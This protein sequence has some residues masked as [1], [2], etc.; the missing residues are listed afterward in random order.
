MIAD[1]V[2]MRFWLPSKGHMQKMSCPKLE[3]FQPVLGLQ[4]ED[5]K[6]GPSTHKLKICKKSDVVLTRKI[7]MCESSSP[8]PKSTSIPRAIDRLGSPWRT[9]YA[10]VSECS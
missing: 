4:Q 6:S 10:R 2:F 5:F 8:D 1:C 7:S 3:N 9:K